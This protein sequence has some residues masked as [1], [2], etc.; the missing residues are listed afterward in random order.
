ME[1]LC[2]QGAGTVE[3]LPRLRRRYCRLPEE[4]AL[5]PRAELSP[6]PST[7]G[8]TVP[9]P[10]SASRAE[11]RKR[12]EL[13]TAKTA[14]S[15]ARPT[16][17][18][19]AGTPVTSLP[20]AVSGKAPPA[21][22]AVPSDQLCRVESSATAAPRAPLRRATAR[23]RRPDRAGPA[24]SVRGSGTAVPYSTI[25]CAAKSASPAACQ[26]VIAPPFRHEHLRNST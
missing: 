15:A 19:A 26:P 12:P 20:L 6:A 7:A 5:S 1:Q 4:T 2:G 23:L 18:S 17:A 22:V 14:T 13:R 8:T 24:A 11:T 25:V 3:G 9:A 21:T 10:E 16:M